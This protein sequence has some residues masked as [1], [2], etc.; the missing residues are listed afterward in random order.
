VQNAL[1]PQ[2][3]PIIENIIS[4][5]QQLL[6]M[7]N[8]QATEQAAVEAA[9]GGDGSAD[10]NKPNDDPNCANKAMTTEDG[11]TKAEDRINNSSEL[12]D[13]SLQDIKKSLT[14][15]IGIMAPK[16][17]A[18]IP[19]AAAVTKSVTAANPANNQ[20]IATLNSMQ[21]VLKSIMDEQQAQKAL[22][23]QLMG[24]MGFSEEV[25]KKS[26]AQTKTNQNNKPVQN[27]DLHIFA[28]E[29][30]GEIFKSIGNQ[31]GS[32]GNINPMPINDPLSAWNQKRDVHKNMRVIAEAI[33]RGCTTQPGIPLTGQNE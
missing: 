32:N 3:K 22:N 5:F 6:S 12:N 10:P 21:T 11:E 20:L 16:Q 4:L 8:G 13:Q 15:L 17:S 9:M 19:Q 27:T 14:A 30:V 28:K 7:Q 24:A 23:D 33:H 31:G 18:F 1:D 26:I 25:V 2:E 29:L